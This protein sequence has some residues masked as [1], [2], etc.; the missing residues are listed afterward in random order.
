MFSRR[1][2]DGEGEEVG[3]MGTKLLSTEEEKLSLLP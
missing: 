3:G 1:G 2:V